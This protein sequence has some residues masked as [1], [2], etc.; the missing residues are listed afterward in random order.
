MPFAEVLLAVETLPDPQLR[1]WLQQGRRWKP[2]AT[3][4]QWQADMGWTRRPELTVERLLPGV[5]GVSARTGWIDV[6]TPNRRG[7]AWIASLGP[8]A[9]ETPERSAFVGQ[10]DSGADLRVHPIPL[11]PDEQAMDW[12]AEGDG[13]LLLS[14]RPLQQG[15]WRSSIQRFTLAGKVLRPG[16]PVTEFDAPLPARSMA[17]NANQRFVGL[18]SPLSERVAEKK[19]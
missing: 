6:A 5:K 2:W 12:Q 1:R 18:G 4:H 15:G 13:W 9:E 19:L 3:V 8:W 7:V 10:I 17:G 14:S 16:S 11:K